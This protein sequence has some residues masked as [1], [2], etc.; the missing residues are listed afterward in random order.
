MFFV[1]GGSWQV[2]GWAGLVFVMAVIIII[3]FLILCFYIYIL[4]IGNIMNKSLY[5][6]RLRLLKTWY[7]SV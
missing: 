3:F 6:C 7:Y 5:I 4:V 1:V 2:L